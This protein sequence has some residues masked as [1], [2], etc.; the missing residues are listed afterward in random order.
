[1]VNV[2][3]AGTIKRIHVN[4]HVIRANKKSGAKEPP[5]TIQ[6]RG[7]SI[8]CCRVCIYGYSEVKYDPV[9]PLSC[10]AHIW[11]ETIGKVMYW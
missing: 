10:G 4:Q 8:R 5:V 11:V 6:N 3:K 2:I 9:K 1:M 7:S